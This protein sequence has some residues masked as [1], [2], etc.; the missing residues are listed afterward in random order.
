[1]NSRFWKAR[2]GGVLA[3]AGVAAW[4]C[5]A[6]PAQAE[7]THADFS[8][9]WRVDWCDKDRP[10]AE[11]G[12]FIVHLVQ[13]G[14]RLCG[15]H[16]GA[17][18]GLSRMDEGGPRSILGQVVGRT[19]VLTIRSGRSEGIYLVSARQR[20]SAIDWQRQ[21]TVQAGNGDIDVIADQAQL[22]RQA[23]GV[24]QQAQQAVEAACKTYWTTGR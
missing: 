3:M 22:T 13:K 19:A 7:A 8:G 12:A 4:L 1:M 23:K 15:T 14:D 10:Q 11:C 24:S 5:L 9:S 18:A 20:S 16:T 21:E 6:G 17:T 2:L